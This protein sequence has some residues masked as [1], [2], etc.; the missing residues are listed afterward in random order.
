MLINHTP[1]RHLDSLSENCILTQHNGSVNKSTNKDPEVWGDR[2][3][4]KATQCAEGSGK[5][6]STDRLA[7]NHKVLPTQ[8]KRWT[9]LVTQNQDLLTDRW[10]SEGQEGT[11]WGL[12][13]VT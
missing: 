13:L 3:R 8:S 4:W 7:K 6:P 12:G 1:I 2:G 11:F 5:G 9:E 10:T